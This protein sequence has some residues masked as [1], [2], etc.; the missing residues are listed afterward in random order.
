MREPEEPPAPPPRPLTR[1]A[2]LLEPERAA[3]QSET[4]RALA[5]PIRLQIIALLCQEETHVGKLAEQLECNQSIV[6]QQLRILRLSRLVEMGRQDGHSV[7][8]ISVPHL[9]QLV[10]C[11]DE[12]QQ[13]ADAESMGG[14]AGRETTAATGN[15]DR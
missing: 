6:S 13:D 11:L 1:P 10:R 15:N 14:A 5:H 12:C 8:R 7:Y 4:L 9:R 2:R 3:R